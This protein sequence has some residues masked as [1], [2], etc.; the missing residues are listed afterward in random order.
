MSQNV[1]K[2][3]TVEELAGYAGPRREMPYGRVFAVAGDGSGGGS[4]LRSASL[5]DVYRAAE[6]AYAP[7]YEQTVTNISLT[8][9]KLYYP[10][11]CQEDA[12]NEYASGVC[13]RVMFLNSTGLKTAATFK[14]TDNTAAYGVLSVARVSSE[15]YMTIDWPYGVDSY[16]SVVNA[17]ATTDV[18][19]R[20][21]VGGYPD[22]KPYTFASA[23]IEDVGDAYR[24]ARIA[25]SY[26]FAYSKL[27]AV[28][29]PQLEKI[30]H[31]AFRG[32][33]ITDVDFPRTTYV[34]K[35][36]FSGCDQLISVIS[37][38][39]CIYRTPK[40]SELVLLV[41]AISLRL[42]ICRKRSALGDVY[43]IT[44]RRLC[45][46]SFRRRRGQSMT[47]LPARIAGNR[48]FPP[49]AR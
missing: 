24:Y 40:R 4:R 44:T 32:T 35:Y 29:L 17:A 12:G 27:T 37:S 49:A 39:P 2:T 18:V 48:C 16:L 45:G 13:W 41:H 34:D 47:P 42:C 14:V 19:L 21:Y 33:L 31:S 6:L 11:I 30:G 36:A 7:T 15:P 9:R 5:D 28:N 23:D 8:G 20:G 25:G 3:E 38:Y 22:V 10:A 1:V 46:R 43:F 26:S